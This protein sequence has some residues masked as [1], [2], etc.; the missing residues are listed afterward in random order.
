[1]SSKPDAASSSS[2]SSTTT[3]TTT[4]L[5]PDAAAAVS[6]RGSGALSADALA[7][8]QEV[9]ASANP[10]T[11]RLLLVPP[12]RDR[13]LAD[14]G[15]PAKVA[16]EVAIGLCTKTTAE[17]AKRGP[18][19]AAE[20]DFV[21]ANVAMALIADF[22][23]VFLPA[24]T[25]PLVVP[26]EQQQQ[27]QPQQQH[28][29]SQQQ[30]PQQQQQPL[31]PAGDVL[32]G[33][34]ADFFRGC[35]ENAFQKVP[36]GRQPFTLAQRLKAPLRNGLK[37]FAVGAG[38]SVVGVAST[39]ALLGLRAALDS[40]FTPL[41]APQDVLATAAAYGLYMAT[42]SNLRYQLVAGVIEER[43]IEVAFAGDARACAALSLVVRTMNTF[44]GSLMWVDFVRLLGMQTAGGAGH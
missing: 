30:Q 8:Y 17:W 7:R 27:Q 28:Q 26:S 12:L 15:F 5:P 22:M 13:L 23:L 14:P 6:A 38:A 43:G 32:A 36:P 42:S 10:A 21:L 40:G 31:G 11:R 41:N 18:A 39:N 3:T 25:L 44:I 29:E 19:F 24:P 20:L 4:P 1:L 16:I 9:S 37:L 35:P 34:L 33:A 2:K